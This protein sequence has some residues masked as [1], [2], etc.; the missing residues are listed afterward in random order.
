MSQNHFPSHPSPP[1][2]VV[3]DGRRTPVSQV[4]GWR[5]GSRPNTVGGHRWWWAPWVGR[6]FRERS[7]TTVGFGF[8]GSHDKN[9]VFGVRTTTKNCGRVF[10]LKGTFITGGGKPCL[11]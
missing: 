3:G 8:L 7:R 11:T 2:A 1:P 10:S 6:V 5:V 4:T 9:E